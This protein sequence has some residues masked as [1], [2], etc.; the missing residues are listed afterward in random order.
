MTNAID[1]TPFFAA[2]LF[3]AGLFLGG[4]LFSGRDLLAK[5]FHGNSVFFAKG[6]I[7]GL[8]LGLLLFQSTVVWQDWGL[9]GFFAGAVARMT[10]AWDF[11]RE[12][13]EIF[14]KPEWMRS[15]AR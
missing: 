12:A 8:A 1:M 15:A 5:L 3:A 6:V 7:F 14:T 11:T 9:F 4:Y 10:G 2:V 13:W